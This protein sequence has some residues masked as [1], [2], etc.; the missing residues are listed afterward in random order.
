MKHAEL[1]EQP[2]GL[3]ALAQR[4]H[5]VE[6]RGGDDAAEPE[7]AAAARGMPRDRRGWPGERARS[8]GEDAEARIGEC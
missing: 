6:G 1:I 5:A 2:D 4:A 3:A 7:E 8:T